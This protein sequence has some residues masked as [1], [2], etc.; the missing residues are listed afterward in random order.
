MIFVSSILGISPCPRELRSFQS[1]NCPGSTFHP[2]AISE[3]PIIFLSGIEYLALIIDTIEST[4]SIC[5]TGNSSLPVFTISIPIL[6]EFRDA[7]PLH[8]LTPPCQADL[9]SGTRLSIHPSL[10]TRKCAETLSVRSS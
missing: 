3:C 6:H 4:L 8:E 1:K 9:S 2:G 5:A 10:S 7:F